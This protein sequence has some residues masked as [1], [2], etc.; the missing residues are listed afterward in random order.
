MSKLTLY[1]GSRIH[2]TRLQE[3]VEGPNGIE[4]QM[5]LNLI[6]EL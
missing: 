1:W 6:N 3:L 5:V 2:H 4:L